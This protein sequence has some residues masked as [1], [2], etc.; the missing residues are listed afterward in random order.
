[1]TDHARWQKGCG[2]ILALLLGFAPQVSFGEMEEGNASNEEVSGESLQK[3]VET[4]KN[5]I[6]MLEK[7][8]PEKTDQTDGLAHPLHP[9]HA[10]NGAKLSGGVTMIFQRFVGVKDSFGNRNDDADMTLST[11]LMLESPVGKNG[12]FLLRMDLER[13]SGIVSTPPLFT[14]PDGNTTGTNNDVESWLNPESLNVNEVRYQGMF[15]DQRLMIAFGQMDLTAYFDTNVYANKETYQ[16]I[17]QNFNNNSAIDWG[18]DLNFFGPGLVVAYS[19]SMWVTAIGGWFHGGAQSGSLYQNA[20]IDPW[21]AGEFDFKPKAFGHPGNYRFMVWSQGT[22]RCSF[23]TADAPGACTTGLPEG[24]K[25]R[26]FALSFDQEINS[27]LALWTRFGT[28]DGSV[29]QFD[30]A[31]TIGA[32]M[33]G[34]P[35]G[36]SDDTFGMAYG[37][38]T[39]SGDYPA[40]SGKSGGEH[41]FEIYYKFAAIPNALEIS[42]DIQYIKNPG[43]NTQVD[44]FYILGLRTQVFF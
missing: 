18:G 5:R 27:V 1:M 35:I 33:T 2:W 15:F 40:L 4:L 23:V 28:Q 25:T 20:F 29:A 17:A 39:P 22:P 3:E 43:G 42:P 37:L 9:V 34:E 36:R 8:L 11:D 16:F 14:N 41:Y 10:L 7:M 32:Q 6:D 12:T 31:L 24:K 44:S 13:G 21:F 38:T 19:P 30:R 26:G